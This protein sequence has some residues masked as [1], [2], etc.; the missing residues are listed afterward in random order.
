M[1]RPF[2]YAEEIDSYY[3][4][5]RIAYNLIYTPIEIAKGMESSPHKYPNL[6][7][8]L[9]K[10]QPINTSDHKPYGIH[11]ARQPEWFDDINKIVCV[12]K[13]K[14]PKFV[15]ISD[16]WYG[17]QAVL[18]IR[19]INHN[20][21]SPHYV[22]AILNSA[23]AHFWLKLQKHQGNQLQIDKEVLIHFPIPNIDL[24]VSKAKSNYDNLVKFS[25][26]IAQKKK[27][28]A[29]IKMSGQDLFSE[30]QKLLSSS[31]EKLIKQANDLVYVLYGLD[32]SDIQQIIKETS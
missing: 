7:S 26:K 28:L 24:S 15:V 1:L 19:L 30:K 14:Y 18:I 16:P 17:D 29:D 8:H 12:R 9:D 10:Y 3:Y 32:Q 13:T 11:R 20:K 21:F 27:E 6:I 5:E 31:I 4:N 23:V 22:T 2:H 25:F